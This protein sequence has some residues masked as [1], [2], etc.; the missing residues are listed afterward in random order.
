[1][2]GS[3]EE[4]MVETDP[5]PPS[6][7]LFSFQCSEKA[8]SSFKSWN[9]KTF[10]IF[11]FCA[12]LQAPIEDFHMTGASARCPVQVQSLVKLKSSHSLAQFF[13]QSEDLLVTS[14]LSRW[15]FLWSLYIY[16]YDWDFHSSVSLAETWSPWGDRQ[17]Q[18]Q[19]ACLH[20][21]H[22]LEAPC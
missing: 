7:F 14:P 15:L 3:M 12:W 2:F 21:P 20:K 18:R 4:H 10:F 5:L 9:K 16:H 13:S 11:A 17:L 22:L 19:P 1:M 8:I 6:S